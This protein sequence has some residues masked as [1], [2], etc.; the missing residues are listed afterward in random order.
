MLLINCSE[1]VEVM[2]YHAA[3]QITI[4]I[5]TRLHMHERAPVAY[6]EG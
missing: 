6:T 4:F 3:Q 5:D 2:V 1:L